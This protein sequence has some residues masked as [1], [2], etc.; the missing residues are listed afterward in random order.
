M[1]E[2]SN[3]I[4][5]R[6][7]L[8]YKDMLQKADLNKLAD[9][10]GIP[11]EELKKS[12]EALLNMV[13]ARPNRPQMEL[14]LKLLIIATLFFFAALI[15]LHEHVHHD[16][17]HLALVKLILSE[18]FVASFVCWMVI[19]FVE[20]KSKA[21][22]TMLTNELLEKVK[23][24][25]FGAM[26]NMKFPMKLKD[27]ILETM[28]RTSI[29]RPQL[30]IYFDLERTD[31]NNK[32]HVTVVVK[33]VFQLQNMT[34]FFKKCD[35][36]QF[37]PA[38]DKYSQESTVTH[39]YV[40]NENQPNVAHSVRRESVPFGIKKKV[41]ENDNFDDNP[42]TGYLWQV[43]IELASQAKKWIELVYE[44][45]SHARDSYH[46]A[47]HFCTQDVKITVSCRE[48]DIEFAIIPSKREGVSSIWPEPAKR[49]SDRTYELGK[50]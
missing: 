18:F 21:D 39:I 16:W 48:Q 20:K 25:V 6:A 23:T 8:P 35:I 30:H 1:T 34:G 11:V 32:D 36:K 17:P 50:R 40:E 29:Y 2:K 37:I 43:E 49:H 42:L 15:L 22:Q 41:P 28:Q 19:L 31:P 46:W 47:S 10:S 12:R 9:E 5:D 44:L 4:A 27:E 24:E 26:L 45:K 13:A 14:L 3:V 38:T 33:S 7:F